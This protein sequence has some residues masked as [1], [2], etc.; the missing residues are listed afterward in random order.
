MTMGTYASN[1]PVEI[2]TD[3]LSKSRESCYKARDAFYACFEK[4]SD[5]KPTEIGCV[6]L[7]YPVECKSSRVEYEKS[8]RASW[9]KH[10]DR[11]YCRNKRVQR[12]LD[13]N[14]SRK[15]V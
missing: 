12:L 6:G 1:N 5:K 8:C 10:F 4:E 15:G 7:L 9:V 3:V 14:D 11:L 2:H 13:D